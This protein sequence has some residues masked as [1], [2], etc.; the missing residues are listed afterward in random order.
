M[1]HIFIHSS[2]DGHLGFLHVLAI[3]N[4]VAMNIVVQ[5]CFSILASSVYMPNSGD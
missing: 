4:S 3:V 1:N 2:V 5:K